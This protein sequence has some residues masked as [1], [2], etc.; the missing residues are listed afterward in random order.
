VLKSDNPLFDENEMVFGKIAP[1]SSKTYE[2]TV[3]AS[4][5]SLTRTDVIRAE[6]SGQGT[7]S[8][9]SPEMTLHIEGKAHPLFAYS[10]QTIDDV[11]GNR[12]GQV[13]RGERVRTLVKVKNIGQGAA[14]RTEAILRNGSGQEGILIS[15]GRF[16]TK[17]L[18]P[19]AS[20]TFTFVYEVGSDFRGNEYQLELVVADTVLGESVTDKIK[21]KLAPAGAVPAAEDQPVTITRPEAPLREAPTDNALVVGH[22]PKGTVWR[23]TGRIGGFCRVEIESGRPA[24]V[25]AADVAPGGSVHGSFAPAW[26]VTPPILTVTAPTLVPGNTVHLKATASD[27]S[28]VKDV[29]IRVWNRDSKLPPKKVFYLPNKGNKTHLA[30]ET[31]VPLWPGSNLVQVFARETNEIQSVQTVVVLDRG[32]PTVVQKTGNA[33]GQTAK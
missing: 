13:Q 18:A 27:D 30:F 23:S 28:G 17:E 12:D 32:A 5:S 25:A 15:A 1:G 6:M 19:G 21:V 22:A 9:N 33:A 29:Y 2:L 3:K 31:D 11:A 20:R 24:F 7:L 26:H 14:L 8:A 16:D 10:Y 4:K